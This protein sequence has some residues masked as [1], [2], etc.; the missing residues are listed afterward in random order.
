MKWFTRNYGIIENDNVKIFVELNNENLIS[1]G[2][3][4]SDR[5]RIFGFSLDNKTAYVKYPRLKDM[6][7]WYTEEREIINQLA[8][9]GYEVEN[10][11]QMLNEKINMKPFL[12]IAII[13]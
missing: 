1:N 3:Y 9:D 8:K 6:P 7:E 12:I 10:Y 11:T 2:V 13:T 4:D 5:N